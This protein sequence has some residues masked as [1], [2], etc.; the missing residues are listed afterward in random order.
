MAEIS[1]TLQVLLQEQADAFKRDVESVLIDMDAL[2]FYRWAA[3]RQYADAA[4]F[5][6]AARLERRKCGRCGQGSVT[7]V[8]VGPYTACEPCAAIISA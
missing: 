4:K 3:D 5:A 7:T 8:Q 2:A 6:N 1:P